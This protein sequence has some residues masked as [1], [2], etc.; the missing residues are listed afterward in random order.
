[1]RMDELTQCIRTLAALDEREVAKPDG[2]SSLTI[3]LAARMLLEL[4]EDSL[5]EGANDRAQHAL[6]RAI[7]H[8]D[9]AALVL[10]ER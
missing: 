4:A 8:A 5:S 6:Q 7:D 3:V 9:H 10:A 1:M 2:V